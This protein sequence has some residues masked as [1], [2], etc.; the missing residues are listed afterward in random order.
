[1]AVVEAANDR[2]A[3]L[4]LRETAAGAAEVA[5]DETRLVES[6]CT[7]ATH[8]DL[9]L[10]DPGPLEELGAAGASLACGIGSRLEGIVL[11]HHSGITPAEDLDEVSGR[12]AGSQIVQVGVIE[13]FVAQAASL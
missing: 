13:N 8:Y 1:V 9:V 3:V 7:L 11:V 4:P 10:L 6:I 2:L 5:E 12:L